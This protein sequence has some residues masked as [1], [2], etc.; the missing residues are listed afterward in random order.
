MNILGPDWNYITTDVADP[1]PGGNGERMKFV[2]VK[3]KVWFQNIA[4]EI[5]LPARMLVSKVKAEIDGDEFVSGK[6]FRRC[7]SKIFIPY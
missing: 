7:L 2:Y 6:Q 1:V 4:G 3:H 5:V